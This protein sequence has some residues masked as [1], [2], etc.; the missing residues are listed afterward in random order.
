MIHFLFLILLC[1]TKCS[2]IW[3]SMSSNNHNSNSNLRSRS[4][5]NEIINSRI[6]SIAALQLEEPYIRG[7]SGQQ[8][9]NQ[10]PR[11]SRY[12]SSPDSSYNSAPGAYRVTNLHPNP[13]ASRSAFQNT[14]LLATA[15]AI[16][17]PQTTAEPIKYFDEENPESPD[18]NSIS[19]SD[20]SDDELIPVI[21]LNNYQYN[22]FSLMDS[23]DRLVR[24]GASSNRRK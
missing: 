21:Y 12:P 24:G 17:I 14:A 18:L 6:A 23:L 2:N 11:T 10:P 19:L 13:H 9:T 8:S 1:S 20:D 3:G 22:Q 15:T 5:H 7:P 16:V 4:S